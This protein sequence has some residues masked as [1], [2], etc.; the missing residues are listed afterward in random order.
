MRGKTKA[1]REPR[2]IKVIEALLLLVACILI[3]IFNAT[4]WGMGTGT[5]LAYCAAVC[6][7]Y[8]IFVLKHS[9]KEFFHAGL[10]ICNSS[11]SVIYILL[12]CGVVQAG[13]LIS[14]T[15]PYF[16]YVGLKL[17]SPATYLIVTFVICFLCGVCS[18]NGWGLLVTLG[19]A[20]VNVGNALG[21]PLPI[22]VGAIVGGCMSADRWCPLGD[23]FNLCAATSGGETMKQFRSMT[24]STVVGLIVS[25]A[26]YIVIGLSLSANGSVTDAAALSDG[27]CKAY[28]FNILC[29]IPVV[30]IIGLM[31]IGVDTVPSFLG[32]AFVAL[33]LGCFTQGVNFFQGSSMLWSGYVANTGV[34]EID[35]LLSTGGLLYNSSLIMLIFVAFLFAGVLN[36]LGVLKVLLTG[37][38]DKLKNCG[39]LILAAELTALASVFISTSVYVSVILTGEIYKDGFRRKGL[40]PEVLGRSM[41]EGAAFTSCYCPW[42]GGGLLVTSALLANVWTWA[43]I[44]YCFVG[45][46]PFV[47]N[48]VFAFLGKGLTKARYDEE[49]NLIEE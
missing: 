1:A 46:V 30:V 45:W 37:I 7:L 43:W 40:A 24:A 28:N 8:G 12:A 26:A 29:I 44:P 23:T 10:K 3:L 14:G 47:A 42:S 16:I 21:V 35:T 22:S 9:W 33:I 27:L 2:E 49:L 34:E 31:M 41:V 38:I 32:S 19:L 48:I 5:G 15:V 20:L 39:S 36:T 6:F 4:K 25:V 13:W 18:G 17:L 11:L